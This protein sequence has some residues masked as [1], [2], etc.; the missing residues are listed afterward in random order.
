MDIDYSKFT[1][2]CCS[3]DCEENKKQIC[4][5]VCKSYKD[6]IVKNWAC[7]YLKNGKPEDC[8]MLY[9]KNENATLG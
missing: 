9:L 4:C 7:T 1:L 6:C 5:A 2:K 8:R 3:N